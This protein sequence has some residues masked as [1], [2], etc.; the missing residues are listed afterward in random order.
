MI[1]KLK[2]ALYMVL[3]F[4]VTWILSVNSSL[5]DVNSSLL[6][7]M[8]LMVLH[9]A[10]HYFA[11][12][13]LKAD[14][15]PMMRGLFIGFQVKTSSRRRFVAIALAPQILTLLALVPPLSSIRPLFNAALLHV[16]AS[17]EDLRRVLHHVI[18]VIYAKF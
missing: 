8:L 18:Q 5:Q 11:A 15:R 13:T 10:L 4:G 3:G 17:L 9:E 1:G 14:V 6:L 7:L 16:I 2:S 12:K